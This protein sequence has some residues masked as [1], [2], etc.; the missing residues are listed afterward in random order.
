M[1]EGYFRDDKVVDV[2][3]EMDDM[4]RSSGGWLP[5]LAGH[6]GEVIGQGQQTCAVVENMGKLGS[7]TLPS[8]KELGLDV[9]IGKR[10]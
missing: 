7:C 1:E 5:G 8:L 10:T 3:C 6:D 2:G 4:P 9:Y